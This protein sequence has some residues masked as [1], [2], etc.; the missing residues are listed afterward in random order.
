M[1]DESNRTMGDVN[2]T[3]PY[4]GETFGTAFRR[5]PTVAADGGT[6]NDASG[7]SSD[8]RS[9]G[10]ARDSASDERATMRTVDHTPPHGEGA[11]RVWERGAEPAPD[12]DAERTS[13]DGSGEGPGRDVPRGD[14]PTDE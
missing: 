4:T 12:E 5:G 9:D 10:G 3:H 8:R 2:H 14:A 7:A 1:S 6:A 11:N 13:G